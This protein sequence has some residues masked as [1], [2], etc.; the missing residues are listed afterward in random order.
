MTPNEQ[1]YA[2]QLYR[3][4]EQLDAM[5]LGCQMGRWTRLMT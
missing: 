3:F 2:D 4:G 1:R 5:D